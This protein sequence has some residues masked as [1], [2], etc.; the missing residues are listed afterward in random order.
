MSL[1]NQGQGNCNHCLLPEPSLSMSSM[2]P[3]ALSILHSISLFLCLCLVKITV[4]CV[5]PP[6][7]VTLSPR[8][9]KN[10][11]AC[12]QY[13]CKMFLGSKMSQILR[14]FVAKVSY[15]AISHFLEAFLSPFWNF[16]LF[17]AFFCDIGVFWAFYAVIS[18]IRFVVIYALF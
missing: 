1:L 13:F 7:G 10:V 3:S 14:C 9:G 2:L 5:K 8:D 12:E 6:L 4:C 18:R 11:K 17:L 16:M 15:V